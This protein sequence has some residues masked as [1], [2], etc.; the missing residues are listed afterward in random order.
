M[1]YSWTFASLHRQW[2]WGAQIRASGAK[3]YFRPLMGSPSAQNRD[4]VTP[5]TPIDVYVGKDR[6]KEKYLYIH[7]FIHLDTQRYVYMPK[8][9]YACL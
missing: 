9:L 4:N 3:E 5:L 1:R 8:S 7:R 6:G 2:S